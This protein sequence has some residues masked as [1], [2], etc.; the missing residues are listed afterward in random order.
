M[1]PIRATRTI[2]R[3][4]RG[5]RSGPEQFPKRSIKDGK[6]GSV[7]KPSDVYAQATKELMC[8]KCQEIRQ[9]EVTQ[10]LRKI[11]AF[12]AVCAH[13]WKLG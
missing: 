7:D 10:Y 8:P 13:T 4:M 11:E 12:C 5:T 1:A 6:G 3:A 2:P 9:V